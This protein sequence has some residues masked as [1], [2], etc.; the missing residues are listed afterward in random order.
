MSRSGAASSVACAFFVRLAFTKSCE[1]RS[2]PP[3]SRHS[4]GPSNDSSDT[5]VARAR[6]GAGMMPPRSMVI[7]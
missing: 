6:Q 4:I 7:G 2:R 1:L 3:S 5:Y